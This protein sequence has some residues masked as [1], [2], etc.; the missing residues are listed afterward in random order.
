MERLYPIENEVPKAM[1][2]QN[3]KCAFDIH[4]GNIMQ[5]ANGEFVLVDPLWYGSNPYMDGMQARKMEI[6]DAVD[7]YFFLFLFDLIGFQF[8]S[9]S[10]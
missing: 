3:F 2:N 10:Y 7:Y 6:D 4:S 1:Q 9:F 5:R 8:F